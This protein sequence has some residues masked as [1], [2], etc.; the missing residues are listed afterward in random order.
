MKTLETAAA[1][2]LKQGEFEAGEVYLFHQSDA[3]CPAESSLWG[4]VAGRCKSR[5]QLESSCDAELH[6]FVL[7]GLLPSEYRYYRLAT[8]AELHDYVYA[9]ALCERRRNG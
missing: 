5:I 3:A 1:A 2:D 8:R 4:I 7:Y 9:L 6:D